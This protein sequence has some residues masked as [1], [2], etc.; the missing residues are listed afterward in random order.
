MSLNDLKKSFYKLNSSQ[1]SF[2]NWDKPELE[3]HKNKFKELL[4]DNPQ[5]YTSFIY[6]LIS[7]DLVNISYIFVAIEAL[8]EINYEFQYIDKVIKTLIEQRFKMDKYE[9]EYKIINLLRIIQKHIDT[10]SEKYLD[11]E[12]FNLI[13]TIALNF[14]DRQIVI[15]DRDQDYNKPMDIVTTGINSA[16]GVAVQCLIACYKMSDYS[17]Q[18]FNTLNSVSENANE[19]TR[20]CIIYQAAY[21]NH[22]DIQKAYELYLKTVRDFNPLLLG[23]PFHNGHPLFYLMNYNFSGLK[24]IF[25]KAIETEIAGEAFSNFLINAYLN[26]KEGSYK[27]LLKLLDRNKKARNNTIHVI[28]KECLHNNK[29]SLKGWRVIQYL[30]KYDDKENAENY[31]NFFLK[32]KVKYCPEVVTFI[33]TYLK[34]SVS[35][36]RNEYFFKYIRDLISEDSEKCLNWLLMSNPVIPPERYHDNTALNILIESYNGIREYD[37]ENILLEKAMDMFDNLLLIPEYR[38]GH[39]NKFL[40]ELES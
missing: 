29:Y 28:V 20:S 13:K 34:S 31:N 10:E 15:K 35:S 39:L 9:D 6:E 21:L 40:K 22:L 17:D 3:G 30:L 12:I 5:Q 18:I 26:N 38:N 2:D 25:E 24:E 16:R 11:I 33:D 7:D 36:Y 8:Q 37:K 32:L 19:A 4:K 23:I 14:P 27:L 1:R